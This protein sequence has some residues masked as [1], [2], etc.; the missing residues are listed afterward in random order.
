MAK[1]SDLYVPVLDACRLLGAMAFRVNA[2]VFGARHV[3]SVPVGTPDI[4][5]C[6]RGRFFGIELKAPKG[7]LSEGQL[8]WHTEARHAG[9]L[10][11]VAQSV[12]EVVQ[13]LRRET[14]H[15]YTKNEYLPTPTGSAHGV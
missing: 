2:G 9:A 6:L 12:N 10:I 14:V 1:E 15:A 3:R 7:R 5:G 4:L 8:A 11:V 13:E